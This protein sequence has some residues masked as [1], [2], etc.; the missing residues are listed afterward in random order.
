MYRSL[1][2]GMQKYRDRRIA[3]SSNTIYP[4]FVVNART[5]L[6][7]KSQMHVNVNVRCHHVLLFKKND[8]M[9]TRRRRESKD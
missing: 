7:V 3:D 1:K 4:G 8:Q 9:P 2:N 5:N 6:Y